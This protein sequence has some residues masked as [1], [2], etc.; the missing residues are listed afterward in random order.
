MF[1]QFQVVVKTTECNVKLRDKC[2]PAAVQI[3]LKENVNTVISTHNDT[4]HTTGRKS[5]GIKCLTVQQKQHKSI[6][7]HALYQPTSKTG[8]LK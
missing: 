8:L 3:L 4:I 1:L 2:L 7:I 6:F 5:G